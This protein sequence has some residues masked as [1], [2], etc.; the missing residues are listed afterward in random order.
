MYAYRCKSCQEM[1][2]ATEMPTDVLKNNPAQIFRS[3]LAT[4]Y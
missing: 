3:R 1:P 4:T 2:D